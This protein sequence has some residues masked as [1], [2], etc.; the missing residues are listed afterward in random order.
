MIAGW[1][2]ILFGGD[3][4]GVGWVLVVLGDLGERGVWVMWVSWV[5]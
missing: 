1:L 5:S 2:S 4:L 3:G